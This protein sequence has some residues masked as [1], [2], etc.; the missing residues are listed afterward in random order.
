MLRKRFH[1][2]RPRCSHAL[3]LTALAALSPAILC[4]ALRVTRAEALLRLPEVSQT[5]PA[6]LT[7]AQATE[8][9]FVQ[10]LPAAAE[11]EAIDP[12]RRW[13]LLDHAAT[14]PF[15]PGERPWWIGA[16]GRAFYLTDQRIEW[17]GMETTFG[18]QGALAGG[19]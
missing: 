6:P 1:E 17:T 18:V 3:R 9:V 11:A 13:Y 7:L 14:I 10:P 4:A 8:P 16:K 19:V 2:T 12:R 15:L 5:P